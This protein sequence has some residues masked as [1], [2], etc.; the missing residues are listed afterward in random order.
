MFGTVTTPV[1]NDTIIPNFPYYFRLNPDTNKHEMNQRISAKIT[2]DNWVLVPKR[3][4][5]YLCETTDLQLGELINIYV[6]EARAADA[7]MERHDTIRQ[8]AF[9]A[10]RI[11]GER[12]IQESEARSWCSEFDQIISE[13]NDALPGPFMLP[14]REREYEV[15]WTETY[16][17]TVNR[18]ATFTATNE[19]EAV[20]Y[21]KDYETADGDELVSAIR[22]GDWEFSDDNGDYEA[23]EQ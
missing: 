16:T 21:A 17:V 15:T 4:H 2:D 10:I 11:I 22:Y 18:S 7:W 3:A 8:Q 19:D 20:D 6:S 5:N 12:L 1:A 13:V 23:S 9:D 14:V